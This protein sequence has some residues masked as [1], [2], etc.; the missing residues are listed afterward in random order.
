MLTMLQHIFTSY[1][2]IDEIDFEEIAV[3]IMELYDPKESLAQLIKQ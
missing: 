3:N 1:G 2:V